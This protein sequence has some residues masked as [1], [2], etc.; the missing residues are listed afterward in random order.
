MPTY[1]IVDYPNNGSNYG[2]YIGN[3]PKQAASKAFSILARKIELKNTNSK[4]HLK[5]TIKNIN[6]NKTHIY[7]G[8]RVELIEPVIVNYKNG[9]QVTF[10]Y[11]NIISKYNDF[12]K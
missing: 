6:T 1:T 3:T 8:T 5:F 9:N 4:N 10:K 7:V 2:E 11:K 12:V